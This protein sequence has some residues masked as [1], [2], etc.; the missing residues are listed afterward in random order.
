MGGVR[1]ATL[2]YGPARGPRVA[3]Q[4]R[5]RVIEDAGGP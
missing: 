1:I 3:G 2:P 4:A 5:E